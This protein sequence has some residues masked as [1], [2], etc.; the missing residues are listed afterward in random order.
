MHKYT[1]FVL[2]SLLALASCGGGGYSSSNGG[3]GGGG[4]AGPGPNVP[5]MTVEIGPAGPAFPNIPFISVT[6]CAPGSAANCQTIDHIEVDT[7]SWGLRIIAP[8]VLN[9][10]LLAALP[11]QMVGATTTPVA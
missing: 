6:V 5:P 2:S 1:A 4:I 8:G 9:A 10:A 7:G 3:G 11:Q